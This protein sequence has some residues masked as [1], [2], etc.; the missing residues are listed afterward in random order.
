MTTTLPR[1]TD[2]MVASVAP[3]LTFFNGPLGA[4]QQEADVANFAVGNPQELPM[5]AYVDVLRRHLEPQDK[6]WFAYKLS[7][8]K[9]QRTVARTL[10][11]RTGLPWDPAD[12]AMT[13]GGF[14]ALGL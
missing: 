14:A 8:P 3:F 10:T 11:E 6:D 2:R 5:P 7:E 9:S 4:L 1:R 13:N 12:V